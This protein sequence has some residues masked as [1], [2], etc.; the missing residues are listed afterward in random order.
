MVARDTDGRLR[1]SLLPGSC[2]C[3]CLLQRKVLAAR[4][5]IGHGGG[6]A[7]ASGVPRRVAGDVPWRGDSSQRTPAGHPA[8]PPGARH[9]RAGA[10]A[11]WRAR[12]GRGAR[13]LAA[14][15]VG[16]CA[17]GT[18]EGPPPAPALHEAAS[19]HHRRRAPECWPLLWR[20]RFGRAVA[21]RGWGAGTGMPHAGVST[22]TPTSAGAIAAVPV[23]RPFGGRQL[24]VQLLRALA[25][26]LPSQPL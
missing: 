17:G 18:A 25:P 7:V 12:R 23:F 10:R 1:L 15:R 4:Y 19:E 8:G 24:A 20:L 14:R 13:A 26:G 5:C 6:A 22:S 9:P 3:K 21:R 11:C 16:A 2:R